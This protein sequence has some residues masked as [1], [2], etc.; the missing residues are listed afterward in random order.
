MN[1]FIFILGFTAAYWV[2]WNAGHRVGWT[3]GYNAAVDKIKPI[4][5]ELQYVAT[6]WR[7]RAMEFFVPNEKSPKID[8]DENGI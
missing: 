5:D 8:G 6:A 1:L 3:K 2:G 7:A 4:A